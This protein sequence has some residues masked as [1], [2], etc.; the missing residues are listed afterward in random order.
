MLQIFHEI[1]IDWLGKRRFF[2]GLSIVL[3]LAGM[4]TALY[5]H[6]FHPNGTDAFNLGVDFKGGTVVTVRF[7][8]PPSVEALRAAVQATGVG[9]AVIQPVLDRQGEFLIKVPQQSAAPQTE[10][11]QTQVG[12]D[13]ARAKVGQALKTFGEGNSEIM[14][15]DAVSAVASSQLR[16]QAIAVTIAAL[17]GMLLFIAFRF[18]WTYGASAVIA[19]FHTVLVTLGL[20]SIFQIEINL[21]VIAAL[22]TLVGFDVNDSI[23]IFDR[24]RENRK[25][26]R[27]MSLYDVTNKSINQTLSRTV[28]TSGLVFLSVIALVLLGGETLRPFSL[29]LLMGILF[30]TYD[31]IAI[32]G[33]IMVWWE[34]RL[35][36][37]ER[38]ALAKASTGRSPQRSNVG[39]TSRATLAREQKS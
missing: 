2:I 33:P 12:V 38:N 28:I 30:G 11:T 7:K 25:L 14:G 34:R 39:K 36:A 31:T 1:N 20:F 8:Q 23:V 37:S 9:D 22:L 18:E 35:A 5:R 17:V 16:T 19:V 27:R 10:A 24:I 21:T 4:G 13:P 3:M 6:Q 15:T 26:H 32:A 29:A